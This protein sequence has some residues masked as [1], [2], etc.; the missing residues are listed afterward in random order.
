MISVIHPSRGRAARAKKA[1]E[2]LKSRAKHEFQYIISIDQDDPQLDQYLNLFQ[3]KNIHVVIGNNRSMVD[4]AQAGLSVSNGRILIIFS[5]DFENMPSGWDDMIYKVTTGKEF[6][7][8]KVYDGIHKWICTIP[9]VDRKLYEY[10]GHVYNPEYRHMFGDTEL[11]AV[12]DLLG[13][14]LYHNEIKFQ[15][16]QFT[17]KNNPDDINRRNNS[18]WNHDQAV[19]IDRYQNH[20]NLPKEMIKG[21]IKDSAH[22]AWVEKQLK[23][24]S[25]K[26]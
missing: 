15:H 10:L 1:Y 22:I 20:F 9:I 13:C 17:L 2:I 18:F 14:T 23:V 6:F 24:I 25:L 26:R 3:S 21:K 4:A 11:A 5:D 12:C 19:Y 8:L 7:N 16:N